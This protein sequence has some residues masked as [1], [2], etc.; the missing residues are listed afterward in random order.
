M[1]VLLVVVSWTAGPLLSQQAAESGAEPNSATDGTRM[2]APA[3]RTLPPA[4]RAEQRVLE[5]LTSAA[6]RYP[7]TFTRD[8]NTGAKL[9]SSIEV[10]R[11]IDVDGEG[12]LTLPDDLLPVLQMF[13]GFVLRSEGGDLEVFWRHA[14][15]DRELAAWWGGRS[16][17]FAVLVPSGITQFDPPFEL[18]LR[19]TARVQSVHLHHHRGVTLEFDEEPW[20]LPGSGDPVLKVR[21]TVDATRDLAIGGHHE[22]DRSRYMRVYN[23]ADGPS[24]YMRAARYFTAQGFLPARDAG[25][26]PDEW[27]RRVGPNE[28]ML[29]T[30]RALYP[31]PFDQV[32][33][34]GAWPER[35]GHRDPTL[36]PGTGTPAIDR[37]EEA[38]ELAA[39][40][41][42][43]RESAL[44]EF[45]GRPYVEVKNEPDIS[46]NWAYFAA[47]DRYDAWRLLADFHNLV[48]AAVKAKNPG[49]LV[50]GPS[51]CMPAVDSDGFRRGEELLTFM[52]RTHR[53]LDFY[54]FHFYEPNT[55]RLRG[56]RAHTSTYLFGRLEGVFD[57]LRTK[58]HLHGDVKP[59]LV[60]EYGG[61]RSPP[62]DVGRWLFMRSASS[63]MMRYMQMPDSVK[64]SVPFVIPIA[65]WSRHTPTPPRD[66]F[67]L[68]LYD[69]QWNLELTTLRFFLEFWSDFDGVRIP[70]DT[71]G[72]GVTVVALRD[73]RTVY[74][75]INNLSQQRIVVDLEGAFGPTAPEQIEQRRLY[76]E[77][78]KLRFEQNELDRLRGIPVAFDE[79]SIVKIT[80]DRPPP[81]RGLIDRRTYFADRVLQPT[82]AETEFVIQCPVED[83][84]AGV[85]RIALGRQD[86]FQGDLH[87]T[88]NGGPP[89]VVCLAPSR[90]R[91][92]YFGTKEI[93]IPPHRLAEVNRIGVQVSDRNGKI[94]SVVLVNDYHIA[95][96]QNLPTEPCTCA[97][98]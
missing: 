62:T 42:Q 35:L 50:G 85:L 65:F 79:T 53:H 83:L 49:W 7:S 36:P 57:L 33:C 5:Q 34:F 97:V 37:F 68:F 13:R 38:A 89:Q 30:L 81:A 24:D 78:G 41:V 9:L 76:I 66:S 71:D 17:H 64:L 95:A 96:Q 72:P 15:V 73:G 60:T 27:S 10:F 77:R 40:V 28:K 21:V 93:S 14:G 55:F 54:S 6:D 87:V 92:M 80:L 61:Q 74:L 56:P 44:Q 11:D 51:A 12:V 90:K 2:K 31:E 19:G 32:L 23:L 47:P 4:A 59:I 84:A 16:G 82:G 58:M 22:F 39:Q 70:A 1:G 45:S 26:D 63:H 46:R 52:D 94:S 3:A 75:A 8:V 67:Q 48:A 69:D 88:V 20:E 43:G 18:V 86:G 29:R 91:G 25:N 98:P